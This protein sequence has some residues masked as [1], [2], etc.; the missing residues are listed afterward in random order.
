MEEKNEFS[1]VVERTEDLNEVVGRFSKDG[2]YSGQQRD[3][4]LVF[5]R[6]PIKEIR[7]ACLK[8]I[9]AGNNEEVTWLTERAKAFLRI[10]DYP[11]VFMLLRKLACHN[12]EF[13]GIIVGLMAETA[14]GCLID[15]AFHLK[16]ALVILCGKI[17][18]HPGLYDK[19]T[20]EVFR[21]VLEKYDDRLSRTYCSHKDLLLV[22]RVLQSIGRVKDKTL[23]PLIK[24]NSL[25]SGDLDN[26]FR[27]I[28][29]KKEANALEGARS[30]VINYLEGSR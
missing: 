15:Y 8:K 26:L 27:Y 12:G 19:N 6:Y 28:S 24:Q 20:R 22:V 21:G 3:A 2:W 14:K 10:K 11:T 1:G 5:D 23:L 13:Q 7:E 9:Y 25:Q 4:R 17:N 30:L 16:E 29:I 18:H